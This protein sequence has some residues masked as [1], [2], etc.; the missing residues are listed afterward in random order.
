MLVS[1]FASMVNE[2]VYMWWQLALPWERNVVDVWVQIKVVHLAGPKRLLG[3]LSLPDPV[4]GFASATYKLEWF[5]EPK[6]GILVFMR[7]EGV[8][9]TS[10][11]S[12]SEPVASV[13]GSC[14][15]SSVMAYL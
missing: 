8:W 4:I 15:S 14:A 9:P 13:G 12:A 5:A 11:A 2:L 10:Q 3:R 7:S 1:W 6:R